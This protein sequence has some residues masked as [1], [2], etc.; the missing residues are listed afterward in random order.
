MSDIQQFPV[1]PSASQLQQLGAQVR[2]QRKALHVSATVLAEAAAISR[3]T[4]HRIEQGEPSVAMGA[5]NN[6]IAALGL[7]WQLLPQKQSNS[8][9]VHQE[10]CWPAR[11][12]LSEYPQLKELAWQVQGSEYLTPVEANDIYERNAKHLNLSALTPREHSLIRALQIA[13]GKKDPRV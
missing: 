10:E 12:L 5:W 6:V 7:Q 8:S 1:K 13:F 3:V 9:Q 2:A 4:L 11:I